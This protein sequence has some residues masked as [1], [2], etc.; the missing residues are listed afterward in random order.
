L[1]EANLSLFGRQGHASAV[2]KIFLLFSHWLPSAMGRERIFFRQ[3]CLP[4]LP[5]NIWPLSKAKRGVCRND[6]DELINHFLNN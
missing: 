2:K 6:F 3:P 5:A 4:A 1:L